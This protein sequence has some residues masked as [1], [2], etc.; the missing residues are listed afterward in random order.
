MIV[1]VI[2]SVLDFQNVAMMDVV[3][4]VPVLLGVCTEYFFFS[5]DF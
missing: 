4:N 3:K 1:S 2:T 5:S